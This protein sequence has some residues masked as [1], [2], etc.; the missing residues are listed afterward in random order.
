MLDDLR[1]QAAST[2]FEEDEFSKPAYQRP[3]RFLG[4]TPVQTFIIAFLMLIITCI[5]SAAF[6]LVTGRVVLPFLY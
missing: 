1:Q 5:L 3:T 2:G 4:M 6:L